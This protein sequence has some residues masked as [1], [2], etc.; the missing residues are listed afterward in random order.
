MEAN[1]L[2]ERQV[3]ERLNVSVAALRR[4]RVQRRGP[5]FLKIGSMVRYSPKDLESWLAGLPTGGSTSRE[6]VALSQFDAAN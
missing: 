6:A 4:W 1:L 2:N 5:V 3:S